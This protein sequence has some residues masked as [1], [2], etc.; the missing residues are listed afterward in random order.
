MVLQSLF[1]TTSLQPW[2]ASYLPCAPPAAAGLK[3]HLT[4]R[5]FFTVTDVRGWWSRGRRFRCS[6]QGW[7]REKLVPGQRNGYAVSQ[8]RWQSR[9]PMAEQ[10]DEDKRL[11]GP[12]LTNTRGT[13]QSPSSAG[14][15][16]PSSSPPAVVFLSHIPPGG[17]LKSSALLSHQHPTSIP[18]APSHSQCRRSQHSRSRAL[19]CTQPIS[20][21]SLSRMDTGFPAPRGSQALRVGVSDSSAPSCSQH[22]PGQPPPSCSPLS[23]P[24]GPLLQGR[25]GTSMALAAPSAQRPVTTLCLSLCLKQQ[26]SSGRSG[27]LGSDPVPATAVFWKE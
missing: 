18:P 9:A 8:Q 22:K 24:G 27:S 16:F 11:L 1:L 14:G 25:Y 13:M 19:S 17:Y 3:P 12:C 10:Q 5:C 21:F 15:Q 2:S 4:Q 7:R 20:T 6:Q 26:Q 23:L